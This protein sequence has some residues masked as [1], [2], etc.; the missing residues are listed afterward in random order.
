MNHISISIRRNNIIHIISIVIMLPVILTGCTTTRTGSTISSTPASS[1]TN[2]ANNDWQVYRHQQE[3]YSISIP[4]SWTVITSD[5]GVAYF[6]TQE[7]LKLRS[8]GLTDWETSIAGIQ[9]VGRN[10][11]LDEN[12]QYESILPNHCTVIGWNVIEVDRIAARKYSLDC[13]NVVSAGTHKEEHI[14]IPRGNRFTE[15]W[16][17]IEPTTSGTPAPSVD[18][19]VSEFRLESPQR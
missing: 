4:A 7:G 10:E 14:Y 19:L 6:L 16:L 9:I 5:V 8:S 13:D 18:R 3:G 15:L 17:K 11:Q 2:S 12:A 1:E